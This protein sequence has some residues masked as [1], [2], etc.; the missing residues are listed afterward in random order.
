MQLRNVLASDD[1]DIVLCYFSVH[2]KV[3]NDDKKG[4]SDD[5]QTDRLLL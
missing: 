4:V 2:G 1:K 5:G 3:F